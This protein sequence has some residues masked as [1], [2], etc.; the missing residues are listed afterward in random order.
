MAELLQERTEERGLRGADVLRGLDPPQAAMD[1]RRALACEDGAELIAD[2][3]RPERPED[4]LEQGLSFPRTPILLLR[5]C[6]SSAA[7][8]YLSMHRSWIAVA[9][10]RVWHAA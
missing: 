6:C 5:S 4:F 7:D 8:G 10:L 2:C 1:Q 3:F 9:L